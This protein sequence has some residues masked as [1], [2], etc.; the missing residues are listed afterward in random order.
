MYI[1]IYTH[2]KTYM[3]IHTCIYI[4]A[5]THMN[6]QVVLKIND[7]PLTRYQYTINRIT[8]YSGKPNY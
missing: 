5:Y 6:A 8:Q 3:H 7:E 2:A 1:C 4:H